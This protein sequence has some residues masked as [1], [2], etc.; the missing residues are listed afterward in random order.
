MPEVARVA[1]ATVLSL[2]I[3]TDDDEEGALLGS[4]PARPRSSS[5][6]TD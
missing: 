5:S 6:T 4:N 2:R 1:D 3:A